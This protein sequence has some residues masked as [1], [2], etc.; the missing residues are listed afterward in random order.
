[1]NISKYLAAITLTLISCTSWAQ[2]DV[3]SAQ[4][5]LQEK[6]CMACH[7]MDKKLVG[8]SFIEVAKKYGS[9]ASES[10][11]LE[12][13]ILKGGSGVWGMVPMPANT[14][15]SEPEVKILVKYILSLDQ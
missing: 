10:S 2:V 1:M 7:A 9:S 12:S 8:P 11:K 15:V 14:Q 4:K 5:L 6:N 3:K 13:K